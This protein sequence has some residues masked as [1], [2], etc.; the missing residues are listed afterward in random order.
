MI[1]LILTAAVGFAIAIPA[2]IRHDN[3]Q[4]ISTTGKARKWR[5]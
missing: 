4:P 3:D 2:A 1:A 5:G